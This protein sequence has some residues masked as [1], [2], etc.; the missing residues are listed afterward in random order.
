MKWRFTKISNVCMPTVQIDPKTLPSE[1]FSY[2]D[3]SAIDNELK[4]IVA[5]QMIQKTEAP[6][7]ARKQIIA[8][9]I[10]VS[11]V[12][13]NLNAVAMGRRGCLWSQLLTQFN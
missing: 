8:G 1:T 5:Q 11:T 2:I 9:D 4:T 12:R 6:S 3:I 13:P 10:L 7:R